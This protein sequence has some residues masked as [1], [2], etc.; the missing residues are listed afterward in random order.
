MEDKNIERLKE[1]MKMAYELNWAFP[2][3]NLKDKDG[4][5]FYSSYGVM[6]LSEVEK[7]MLAMVDEKEFVQM[8]KWIKEF[9]TSNT[10]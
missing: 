9:P 3:Q 5:D 2:E 6:I 8:K 4:K 10:P 7:C 1:V